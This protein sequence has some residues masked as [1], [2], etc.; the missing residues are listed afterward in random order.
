MHFVWS[1]T[2][3][4]CYMECCFVIGRVCFVSTFRFYFKQDCS[5]VPLASDHPLERQNRDIKHKQTSIKIA[6]PSYNEKVVWI[7]ERKVNLIPGWSLIS[8]FDCDDVRI[9]CHGVL[10]ILQTQSLV[11]TSQKLKIPPR[12]IAKKSTIN[13]DNSN[14]TFN[15]LL[16]FNIF[17]SKFLYKSISYDHTTHILS[18]ADSWVFRV[19]D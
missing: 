15:Q 2:V 9:I 6:F 10:C 4:T 5:A 13:Y 11:H 14:E 12:V 7:W 16:S 3:A 17:A 19:Y 18:N 1:S 8:L